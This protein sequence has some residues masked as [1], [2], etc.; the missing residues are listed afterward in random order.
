[1]TCNLSPFQSF[2]AVGDGASVVFGRGGLLKVIAGDPLSEK[3]ALCS[4]LLLASDL[5][6]RTHFCQL[7]EYGLQR[8]VLELAGERGDERDGLVG[9]VGGEGSCQ[10]QRYPSL[11]PWSCT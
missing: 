5:V 9:R 1:M 10:C 4:V 11:P 6:K 8:L 3:S 2:T 7:V